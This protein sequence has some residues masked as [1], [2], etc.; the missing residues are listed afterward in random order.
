MDWLEEGDYELKELCKVFA[1]LS[2]RVVSGYEDDMW[3]NAKRSSAGKAEL[4][5]EN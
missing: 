4:H 3:V 5:M 1:R 2:E